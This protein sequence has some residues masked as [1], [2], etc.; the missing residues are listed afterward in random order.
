M[1][2]VPVYE[3]RKSKGP[4]FSD[5]TL[6]QLSA[7]IAINQILSADRR[8]CIA[9]LMAKLQDLEVAHVVEHHTRPNRLVRQSPPAAGPRI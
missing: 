7:L 5:P 2:P 4:R 9:L 6:L 8:S 3:V 1:L